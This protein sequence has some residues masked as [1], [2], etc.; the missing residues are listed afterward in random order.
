VDFY[1]F[2]KG[3]A[4]GGLFA[5]EIPYLC[6]MSETFESLKLTPALLKA[7]EDMGFTHPTPIQAKAFSPILSGR[8][9]VGIA[10]TG[11]GKTLAYLLPILRQLN[12]SDSKDPRV[13]IVVPTRELVLQMV[14]EVQALT[15]YMTCRVEG[16]YGG[17][18][19]NTQ[20]QAVSQGVDVV[21][22]T[23]GRL[24]DLVLSR[25][26]LLSSVKFL[27]IDEVDE[28]LSLGFRGQ[29]NSLLEI[30][31]RK[32]QNLLFSATMTEDVDLMI[33]TYFNGP[34]YVEVVRAG[35]PLEKIEQSGYFVHNFYT[36]LN[37]LEH[38]LN[39]D[40]SMKKVLIFGPSKR[41]ADLIHGHIIARCSG[42][43]D[44]IHSNKS[45]NFR[46]NAVAAFEKG[47]LRGLIATDL[48]ARGLD[49]SDVTHV[50][51]ID[52]PA[53][54][55]TYIHRIGR[56]GRADQ[57]GK[58]IVMVTEKEVPFQ[59]AIEALM[60]KPIPML[61]FPEQIEVSLQM[62]PEE[63]NTAGDINY[64]KTHTLKHSKGAFHEK[65]AK[66]AKAGN[67]QQKRRKK[68]TKKSKKR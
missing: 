42:E 58:S 57:G 3:S 39:T 28:M 63:K 29:L 15:A 33:Q 13:L 36:K 59:E 38:L 48:L 25:T 43:F 16:V 52:T 7:L 40:D 21:V 62:I 9:I 46:L 26:L 22:A 6:G 31:P 41:L 8:D 19:I 45:Q 4:T 66:N 5:R 24:L 10:Q 67:T 27:V 60:G 37:L 17:T 34:M 49:V 61:D 35:T 55:E 14:K 32:R 44:I 1:E 65:K 18:N 51:N 56:T 23:P 50:I 64:L 53:D 2:S 47:L 30:M 20:K 11:T 12:Y 54:P 68:T